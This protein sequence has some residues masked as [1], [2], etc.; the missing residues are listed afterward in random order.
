MPQRVF[1]GIQDQLDSDELLLLLDYGIFYEFIP[2]EEW[3]KEDA[4]VVSLKDVEI[5]KNYAMVITTNGGLW[6]YKIGDTVKFTSTFP[7]RFRISGRTKHFINA[8][9]EEVI[10]E[11]AEAAI[12][13]AAEKTHSTIVNF[14]AA[15]VYFEGNGSN[16]AHEWIVEFSTPPADLKE[17]ILLLDQKLREV[18]SDYDAK[19]YKDLALKLPILHQA[20]EG[21]F[22]AWL[23]KKGKLGGQHKV[24]RLSNSREYLDEILEM[25]K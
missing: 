15:P 12:Q 25:M 1:F 14:T 2:M 16:G 8:F 20:P 7:F 13:F 21:L 18:N 17:F 5:G 3:E 4:Q 11:N 6:R 19:R 22:E 9:G 10:V 24:P 23:S